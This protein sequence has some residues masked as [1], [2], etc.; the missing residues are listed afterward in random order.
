MKDR[1]YISII[2]INNKVVCPIILS[3]YGVD[4]QRSFCFEVCPESKP[5][6]SLYV[7]PIRAD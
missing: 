4:M 5:E 1:N 3:G 7:K 2:D 6:N